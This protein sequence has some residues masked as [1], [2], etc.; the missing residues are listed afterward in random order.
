MKKKQFNKKALSWKVNRDIL[1]TFQR[2]ETSDPEDDA[3][4]FINNCVQPAGKIHSKYYWIDPRYR[5][6]RQQYWSPNKAVPFHLKEDIISEEEWMPKQYIQSWH[7]WYMV[8]GMSPTFSSFDITDCLEFTN[9]N[10]GDFS[11]TQKQFGNW[12]K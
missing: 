10:T 12:F 5:E 8:K 4:K 7:N 3:P 11:T 9:V 2:F 1:P 6:K